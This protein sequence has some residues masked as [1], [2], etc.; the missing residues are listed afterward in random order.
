M[1]EPSNISRLNNV[2]GKLYFRYIDEGIEDI[3]GGLRCNRSAIY[4]ISMMSEVLER[5][6]RTEREV[7]Y[8]ISSQASR[9]TIIKLGSKR[10]RVPSMNFKRP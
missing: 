1:K 2:L 9:K 10:H 7:A 5:S 3:E 4:H 8:I 6:G